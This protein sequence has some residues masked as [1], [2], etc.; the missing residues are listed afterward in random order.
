MVHVFEP[1]PT[2]AK[3]VRGENLGRQFL[4]DV[5]VLCALSQNSKV[6]ACVPSVACRRAAQS[7]VGL[8]HA[9]LKLVCT[10]E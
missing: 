10:V 5:R 2:C 4:G 8:E 1:Q 3:S 7:R 6:Y 9:S